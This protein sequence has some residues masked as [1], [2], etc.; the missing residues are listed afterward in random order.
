MIALADWQLQ[1]LSREWAECYGK[2]NFGAFYAGA[3]AKTHRMEEG[4]RCAICG[5]PA[6]NV[7]HY[8]PLSKGWTFHMPVEDMD[9]ELKPALFA[10]CGSGTTG[11][12]GDFHN[13]RFRAVWK[14]DSDEYEDAWWSG[15]LLRYLAPHDPRLYGYGCWELYDT[16]DGKIWRLFE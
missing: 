6:T 7:H 10:L 5:K 8:P 3:N 14:W 15:K 2:P 1:G 4:A 13:G 16:R 12:H 9:I 11:C